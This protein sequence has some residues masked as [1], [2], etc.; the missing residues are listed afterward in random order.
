MGFWS[1]YETLLGKDSSPRESA[2]NSSIESFVDGIVDDPAYQPD[3]IVEGEITPIVASRTSTISCSIKGIPGHELHIGDTVECFNENWIVVELWTD[4]VGIIN[5]VMWLYNDVLRFQNRSPAINTRY[6]VIDDG[7]YSKKSADPDVFLMT[8]TYKMY[9]PM[10]SATERLYVDKRLALGEIYSAD[11]EKILE[12]YKIIGIDRKSKNFGAGSHLM[13]LT[14]QRDIYNAETDSLGDCVCDIFRESVITSEPSVTGSCMITG[15]DIVRIGTKRKY[16]A[17][18]MNADGSVATDV[19]PDWEIDA[20]IIA[21]CYADGNS[22]YIELP[23]DE[24]LIGSTIT[25]R[26][27]DDTGYYGCYEKKVQVTTVG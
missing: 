24:E 22:C 19:A 25:L 13:V 4:K 10:D 8:N 23:L 1:L 17:T 6:C 14:L 27:S 26:V 20:P 12:V 9:V 11:G 7:T 21:V 2:A 18:F 15:R 3:A 5:G 16:V